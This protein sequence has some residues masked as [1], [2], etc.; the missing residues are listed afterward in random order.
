MRENTRN[1][2][3]GKSAP[4]LLLTGMDWR[5]D[6]A[7]RGLDGKANHTLLAMVVGG[8]QREL[9]SQGRRGYGPALEE[10]GAR[11]LLPVSISPRE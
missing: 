11:V 4:C 3:D 7:K 5:E 2:Q 6:A 8:Q 1:F 9:R 10:R